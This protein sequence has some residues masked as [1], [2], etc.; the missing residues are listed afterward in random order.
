MS[1]T[2]V[3]SCLVPGLVAEPMA[4]LSHICFRVTFDVFQV[5]FLHRC[6]L[7]IIMFLLGQIS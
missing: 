5:F 6:T 1:H 3:W 2:D 4:Y 7:G